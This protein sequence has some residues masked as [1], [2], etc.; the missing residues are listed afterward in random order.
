MNLVSVLRYL[1]FGRQVPCGGS[2]AERLASFNKNLAHFGHDWI[3]FA[4]PEYGSFESAPFNSD[5]SLSPDQ[6]R[7]MK[8]DAL[9]T[10]SG[11]KE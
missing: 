6:R 11:P 3:M 2:E 1:A 10:W 7:K 9:S 8:I 4:N 5:Y